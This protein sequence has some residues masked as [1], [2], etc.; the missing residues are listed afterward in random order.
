MH[1]HTQW[2][3]NAAHEDVN[4]LIGLFTNPQYNF[5]WNISTVSNDK[6]SPKETEQMPSTHKLQTN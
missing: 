4:S 5:V 6:N 2:A 3:H 1:T